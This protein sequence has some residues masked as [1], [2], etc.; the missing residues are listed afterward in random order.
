MSVTMSLVAGWR[1][2]SPSYRANLTTAA[3]RDYI[4]LCEP[5]IF[6]QQGLVLLVHR[7]ARDYFLRDAKDDDPLADRVSVSFA[8]AEASLAK[9]C[10][11]A[12]DKLSSLSGYATVHWP[13]HFSQ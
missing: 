4:K 7:S 11:A 13:Q 10:L 8:D 9:M 1:P 5:I 3:L 12:L 6:V 2:N